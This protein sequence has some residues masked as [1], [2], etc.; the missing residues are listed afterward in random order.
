[1]TLPNPQTI[2]SHI[3]I[4][5]LFLPHTRT[6]TRLMKDEIAGSPS[7][8]HQS[9][10]VCIRTSPSDNLCNLHGDILEKRLAIRVLSQDCSSGPCERN[11]ST[12]SLFHTKKRNHLTTSKL[13]R[14]VFC[15]CNLRLLDFISTSPEP[16][17]VNVDKVDIEKMDDIPD[18]PAEEL[19]IYTMLY[20]EMSAP[21]HRTRESSHRAS[22]TRGGANSSTAMATSS[23]SKSDESSHT[24]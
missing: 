19:D 21:A 5:G 16:R 9:I 4:W 23:S 22:S 18:I 11:W 20:E 13:E 12:W 15:H 14:L 24:S 8:S 3:L 17:Q 10:S 6:S 1:M 2:H 7:A